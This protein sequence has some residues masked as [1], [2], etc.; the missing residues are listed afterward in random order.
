MALRQDS[1]RLLVAD[2]VGVGKTVEALLIVRELIERRK[3][4]RFAVVCLPHLCDQWQEE[5]RSKL[6]SRQ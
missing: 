1:V 4:K 6:T 3:I 2:D 5:I